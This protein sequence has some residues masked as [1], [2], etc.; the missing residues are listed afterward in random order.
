[1]SSNY[2]PQVASSLDTAKEAAEKSELLFRNAEER[3]K[4]AGAELEAQAAAELEAQEGDGKSKIDPTFNIRMRTFRALSRL[5]EK[6]AE[7]V[8]KARRAV[9]TLKRAAD[10]ADPSE[11]KNI[12]EAA[13]K[14]AGHRN[15]AA[16]W[17]SEIKK[18]AEAARKEVNAATAAEK[19]L[20]LEEFFSRQKELVYERL[21]HY[22]KIA[23]EAGANSDMVFIAEGLPII[24]GIINVGSTQHDY[25][26]A[27]TWVK[28]EWGHMADPL[29]VLSA[30]VFIYV[31]DRG[32]IDHM[33]EEDIAKQATWEHIRERV[34]RLL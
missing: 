5:A 4:A 1:M 20:N 25:N 23:T 29:L 6:A 28:K 32:A 22:D 14:A 3:L 13:E 17:K 11:Q 26:E 10:S 19:L 15:T 30:L 2:P 16:L 7:H 34:R 8:E 9:E 18:L 33:A 12:A 27:I 24:N 21:E 31:V